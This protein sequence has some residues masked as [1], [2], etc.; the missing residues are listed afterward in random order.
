M[1]KEQ[2]R[3]ISVVTVF[4]G[5]QDGRQAFIDL[6]L[7]KRRESANPRHLRID[8]APPDQYT[9]SK[10]FSDVRVG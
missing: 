8:S 2:K 7:H 10:V 1:A 3:E 6:I 9:N 5:K 4:D